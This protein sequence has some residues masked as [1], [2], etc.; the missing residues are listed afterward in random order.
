MQ[1]IGLLPN[2]AEE[3]KS[4]QDHD[5]TSKDMQNKSSLAFPNLAEAISRQD[6]V[7]TFK[8]ANQEP[9]SSFQN[10]AQ[11]TD[12]SARPR[13]HDTKCK[14]RALELLPKPG[15]RC[16]ESERP[17]LH[18]SNSKPR[19]LKLLLNLARSG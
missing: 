19:A 15:T 13:L 14:S 9:S 12:E 8:R 3:A 4:Q 5:T 1:F 17:R 2:L 18:Y 6:H 11:A 10:L 16:N 7:Y